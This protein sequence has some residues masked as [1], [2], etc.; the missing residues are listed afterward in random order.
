MTA[1]LVHR[2]PGRRR[3]LVRRRHTDWPSATAGWPWSGWVPRERSPCTPPMGG[4]S[5]TTTASSTTTVRSARG[6]IGEGVAFRGGSDTEVLVDAVQ[7]WGLGPA[8]EACEGMFALALWDRHRRELHLV[9]DRFGE[10]PLYYGWVGGRLAFASELKSLCL[11]PEFRADIDRDAVALYLRHNCVPAPHTIYRGVAKLL[12]GHLLT[13]GRDVRPGGPLPTRAYWS[14]RQAVEE[15][16]RR[17]VGRPGRGDGRP[18]GVGPLRLG[19]RPDGGRRAGRGLPVRRCGLEH[20]RGAHATAQRRAGA[21][22]HRGFR[23]P[24]LRRVGRGRLGGRPPRDRPHPAR[25]D[26]RRRRWR[27][28][29]ACRTSGTSP[30]AT[31]RPSPCTWSAGWPAPR[32]PWPCPATAAT[33]CSPGTTGMPGS[34]SCGGGPRSCPARPGGRPGPRWAVSPRP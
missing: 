31:S 20:G 1:V 18:A 5:S 32:S 13:V 9:R 3:V 7:E 4:G 10:K 33:S 26:R 12:P 8:L 15:A 11:L 6:S 34:S 25:R 19:G 22:L 29:P 21:H 2:G 28:S 24:G 14:A 30:S 23:R 17:P 16:R 27:S